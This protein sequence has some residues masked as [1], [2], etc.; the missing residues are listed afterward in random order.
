MESILSGLKP[1]LL[2]KHFDAI[3]KI[4]H[5][6]KSE[7]P[8]AAYVLSEAERIG[9]TAR[10]DKAG[11]VVVEKKASPGREQ[12][13]GVVLQG[14]LDMV[15]EKN[16]DVV[17]DFSSDPIQVRVEDGWVKAT[18]TTLGAD[19]GIG[20]AAALSVLEDDTLVHG[21]LEVLLTVDEETGLTGANRLKPG[22]IH[23][24]ILLNLD[25]EEEGTFFIGCAGGADSDIQFPVHRTAR[26]AGKRLSVSLSGLRG[27]HSGI[28]IDTGR[29]NAVQLLARLLFRTAVPFGLVSL[30]GG[31]KHNAI[32]REAFAQLLVATK[33][34]A[35]LKKVL[36]KRFEEI[37][38]EYRAVEKDM[39]FNVKP[40]EGMKGKP[41]DNASGNTFLALL[42]ALP[43][44]VMAMSQEIPGLVET[45]NNV[46]IVRCQTGSVQIYTSS[47]S[48]VLSAL[49]AVRSK[50]ES[51][52]SL[53]GAKIRH[54]KGYPAWTPNLDSMLL[55]TMKQVHIGITGKDPEIKAIHAGLEC[56]ILGERVPGMDMISFGP[57]L[58]NPHSPDEKVAV[59]SVER[60]YRLLSASLEALV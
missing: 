17:H 30:E 22:F 54:L 20:V 19:N 60:F 13:P 3:C 39:I 10:K 14:H 33:D 9:C 53:A 52:A 6:S 18:G 40:D 48:S 45:S 15:C 29:G 43:H 57:N 55:K 27:G 24:K 12:S 47:R 44:G 56:G 41:M 8:L 37:R 35:R 21:P 59:D 16:S 58:R 28:D 51:V 7:S 26:A 2:W 1:E 5:C 11:N 31:N 42:L 25:S 32:P 36:K 34:E 50:I 38:F 49:E 46:A 4:P 23:G